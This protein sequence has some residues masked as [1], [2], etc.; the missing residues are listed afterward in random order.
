MSIMIRG[1]ERPLVRYLKKSSQIAQLYGVSLSAFKA[2][3][4]APF[5]IRNTTHYAVANAAT[6]WSEV[7]SQADRLIKIKNG[8]TITANCRN[9]VS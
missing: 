5:S 3:T 4:S 7:N 6:R 1:L 2:L 8:F 9:S